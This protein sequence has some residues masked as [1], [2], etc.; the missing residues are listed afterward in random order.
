M[1]SFF[2]I[3]IS[4]ILEKREEGEVNNA[5]LTS[6]PLIFGLWSCSQ[7]YM[8]PCPACHSQLGFPTSPAPPSLIVSLTAGFSV[9]QQRGL[10]DTPSEPWRAGPRAVS[11]ERVHRGH[12]MRVSR[13]WRGCGRI[14]AP[15]FTAPRGSGQ[16]T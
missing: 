1:P 16:R 15:P 3:M 9:K 12:R 10:A 6:V 4:L 7:A 13:A 5:L 14:Q 11:V 2:P 8:V